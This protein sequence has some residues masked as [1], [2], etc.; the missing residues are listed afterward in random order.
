MDWRRPFPINRVFVSLSVLGTVP[1]PRTALLRLRLRL[2]F[3]FLGKRSL[4]CCFVVVY[5]NP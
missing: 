2:R 3:L 4:Q 1:G 5:Q